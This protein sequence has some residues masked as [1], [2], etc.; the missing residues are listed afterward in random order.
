[1]ILQVIYVLF[2]KSMNGTAEGGAMEN[3]AGDGGKDEKKHTKNGLEKELNE[4]ECLL[5]A[6]RTA[7]EIITNLCC[8]DDEEEVWEDLDSSDASSDEML[9]ADVDM[10]G[11]DETV[12]SH[13][14]VQSEVHG[15]FVGNNLVPRVMCKT[16]F[17]SAEVHTIL[18]GYGRGKKLLKSIEVLQS[19]SLLCVSNM[20]SGMDIEALGGMDKLHLIWENLSQLALNKQAVESADLLEAVTSAMR[21]TIQ[22]LAEHKSPKFSSVVPSDLQFVFELGQQSSHPPVKANAVRILSTI[23]CLLAKQMEPHSLLKNIGTFLV[24]IVSKDQE[25][26]VVAEALDAIFDVFAE[27][28]LDS[29]VRE[30][31]LTDKLKAVAPQLKAKIHQQKRS[32]GDHLPIIMTAR[33]NL[34]RFIKY[35][36]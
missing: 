10:E 36:S 31:G 9:T 33:T 35:K 15:A 25:L 26:W 22:K 7:L 4:L 28:H 23:G 16:N 8:T 13:L 5:T 18:S 14:C 1:M 12:L 2:F 20:V 21:A 24:E 19:R 32:L 11:S 27:D 30:I 3:G 34:M 17:P 29:V 6:Q